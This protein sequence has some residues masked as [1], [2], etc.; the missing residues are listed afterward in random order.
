[1]HT[2]LVYSMDTYG[3]ISQPSISQTSRCF[4]SMFSELTVKEHAIPVN[5]FVQ[6]LIPISVRGISKVRSNIA[7]RIMI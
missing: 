4:F 6:F 1:M 2:I 7:N 3:S 5:I